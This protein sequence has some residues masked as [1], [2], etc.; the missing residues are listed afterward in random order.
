MSISRK[1]ERTFHYPFSPGTTNDDRINHQYW[2]DMQAWSGLVHTEKLDGENTCLNRHGVFAR[3]HAAPTDHPWAGYLKERWQLIRRD[4]GALEVFG[5]NLYAIH[6]I[7]YQKLEAHFF[8]FAVREGDRWLPWEAVTF[9]AGLLDF[10]VVPVLEAGPL[11]ELE[12]HLSTRVRDLAQSPSVFASVE[13]G[14]QHPCTR[15]GVVTRNAGA[16]PAGD[17]SKHAFKYVR[18]QHVK[19]DLH[20]RRNWRRAPLKWER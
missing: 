1:Y 6:S 5:E 10:P 14:G 18:A 17:L 12:A 19:T 3:S 7:E 13:A 9:Y 4:L 8:V 16:F 2:A 11:P 20:W 15:E